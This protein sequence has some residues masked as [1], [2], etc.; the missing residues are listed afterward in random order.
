MQE[1]HKK[2][3]ETKDHKKID[4]IRPV[5]IS[6]LDEVRVLQVAENL[7]KIEDEKYKQFLT[8]QLYLIYPSLM[9]RLYPHIDEKEK[10]NEYKRKATSKVQLVSNFPT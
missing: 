10:E 3:H 9:K 7:D 5:N 4:E 2:E 8:E 6:I 1:K